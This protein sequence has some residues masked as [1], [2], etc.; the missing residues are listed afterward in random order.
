MPELEVDALRRGF[1][2]LQAQ[3]MNLRSA[4]PDKG[5]CA[6]HGHHQWCQQF[7]YSAKDRL[8]GCFPDKVFLS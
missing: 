8:A 5:A 6:K 1:R 2:Q 7:R 3:P 4:G